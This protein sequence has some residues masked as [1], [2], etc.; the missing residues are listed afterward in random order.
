[1]LIHNSVWSESSVNYSSHEAKVRESIS[2]IALHVWFQGHKLPSKIISQ[3]SYQENN[4]T[5]NDVF[6]PKG[7]E[8]Y[9]CL[10]KK[11]F[12][13]SFKFTT[14]GNITLWRSLKKKKSV[15]ERIVLQ[16]HL[17]YMNKYLW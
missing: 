13:P 9:L 5:T 8:G 6:V 16:H 10:D 15:K 2:H 7:K 3:H 11:N 12:C 17:F 14:S 4:K 1:M